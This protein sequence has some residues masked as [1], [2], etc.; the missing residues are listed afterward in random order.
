M[1]KLSVTAR[2]DQE[3][4]AFLDELG[5]SV[6]RDRSYLIRDAVA[7]YVEMHRRQ[8][9]QIRRGIAEADAGEFASD[10]EVGQTFR[11]LTRED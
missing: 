7:Q 8:V 9:Q 6:D 11:R 3:T 2:L 10:R 5:R 1:E 4:V